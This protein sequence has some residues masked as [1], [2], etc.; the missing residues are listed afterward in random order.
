MNIHLITISTTPVLYVHGFVINSANMVQVYTSDTANYAVGFA[1]Q[2]TH[3]MFV[4]NITASYCNHYGIYVHETTNTSIF[5]PKAVNNLEGIMT[6]NDTKTTIIEAI[7][8]H[9]G[10]TGMRLDGTTDASIMHQ[11][12]CNVQW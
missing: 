10:H 8:A 6:V 7:V 4:T 5:S 3:N 2:Y 12:N 9:N 11:P 1:F